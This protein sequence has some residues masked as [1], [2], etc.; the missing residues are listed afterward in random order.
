M[1]FEVVTARMEAEFKA[2]VRL[3]HL[4]YTLALRTNEV[5]G[6]ELS[7]MRGVEVLTRSE[8]AVLALFP[9]RWRAEA[10]G[11]LHPDLQLDKLVASTG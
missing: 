2:P 9:D 1:Q 7:G 6:L 10:I 5:D 11:R 3:E 8:G 4:S